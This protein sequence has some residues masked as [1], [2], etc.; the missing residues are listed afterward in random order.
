MSDKKVF[1]RA[2]KRP[3]SPK[4]RYQEIFKSIQRGDIKCL[5]HPVQTVGVWFPLGLVMVGEHEPAKL[6]PEA[7]EEHFNRSASLKL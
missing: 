3:P 2:A 4:H 7:F 1:K 5:Y 6:Q